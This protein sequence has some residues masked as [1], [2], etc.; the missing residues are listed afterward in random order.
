MIFET[1]VTTLNP[2]GSAHSSPMGV[3]RRDAQLIVAPF[4][5][6]TTLDNLLRTRQGVVNM[7]DD[8]RIIAGCLTGRQDWPTLAAER[9]HGQRLCAALTHVEVEVETVEYD[10]LRPRLHCRAVH[11]GVHAPFQGF[12][13]AQAAVVEAAILVSRLDRLP[14]EKV[15]REIDYL[16]IAVEKTGG[17]RERV[18][19]DWLLE[20]IRAHR[21]VEAPAGD[22]A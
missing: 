2:D 18:A 7:T 22:P 9:V 21:A 14:P 12:N 4:S 6:S 5:P 3:R 1:V 20:R 13:R 15:D 16:S 11:Q 10:E 8:V 17:D 19:W